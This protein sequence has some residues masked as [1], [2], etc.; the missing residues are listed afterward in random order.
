MLSFGVATCRTAN[1]TGKSWKSN[2]K[3]NASAEITIDQV[4]IR[5][6]S[7]QF[8]FLSVPFKFYLFSPKEGQYDKDQ[9]REGENNLLTREQI[10]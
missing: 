5:N 9:Q 6:H 10:S 3:K 1:I 2:R 8:Q 4:K 7:F